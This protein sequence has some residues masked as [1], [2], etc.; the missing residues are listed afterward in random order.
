VSRKVCEFKLT[1]KE[2]AKEVLALSEP[3]ESETEDPE[4]EEKS[5]RSLNTKIG[6]HLRQLRFR[7]IGQEKRGDPVKWLVSGDVLEKCIISHGLLHL[8]AKE[9]DEGYAGENHPA[10][11]ENLPADASP[12]NSSAQPLDPQDT[13][14]EGYEGYEVMQD[15]KNSNLQ[16]NALPTCVCGEPLPQGRKVC[17]ACGRERGTMAEAS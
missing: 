1:I 2:V 7:R 14:Y 6:V 12:Q 11:S 4:T 13:G 9:G 8:F 15:R 10:P 3:T 16:E 5:A 17:F